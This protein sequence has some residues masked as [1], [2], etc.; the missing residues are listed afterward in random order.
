VR[1]LPRPQVRPDQPPRVL[2]LFAFFQNIDEAGLYSFFTP[3]PPTPALMLMDEPAKEKMA[4]LQ[5]R[6]TDFGKPSG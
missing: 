3:S 1:A 6:V 4:G 2:R 5:T